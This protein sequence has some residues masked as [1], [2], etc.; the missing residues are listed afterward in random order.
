MLAIAK[1]PPELIEARAQVL[2]GDALLKTHHYV[3]AREAY[4]VAGDDKKLIELGDRHVGFGWLEEA[5]KC[6]EAAG[7]PLP[8]DK[9]MQCADALFDRSSFRQAEE[10]YRLL[11]ARE[12]LLLCAARYLEGSGSFDAAM[13]IYEDLGVPVP[14]VNVLV[15]AEWHLRKKSFHD[16]AKAYRQ[17]KDMDGLIQCADGFLARNEYREAK[18]LYAEA[19]RK[20][21]A[22]QIRACAKKLE[23]TDVTQAMDAYQEIDDREGLRRVGDQC[24][25]KGWVETAL[26][27]YEKAHYVVPAATIIGH[28]ELQLKEKGY[29]WKDH[30]LHVFRI[31][32]E[33]ELNG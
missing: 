21:T 4:A 15:H 32:A 2:L 8:R 31:L 28:L 20:L 22:D 27:A 25:K 29:K 3:Q 30:A 26:R 24:L 5:E 11:E 16:A 14:R 33:R 6:Y 12:K 18:S 13:K 10:I 19:G 17:A 7:V 23:E 1:K 9:I